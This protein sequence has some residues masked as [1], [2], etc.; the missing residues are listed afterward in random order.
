MIFKKIKRKILEI[1]NDITKKKKETKLNEENNKTDENINQKEKNIKDKE[2]KE[3][4]E[5]EKIKIIE[6]INN[7]SKEEEISLKERHEKI[8]LLLY[9][10]VGLS[11][12]APVVMCESSRCPFFNKGGQEPACYLP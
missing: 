4:K 2:N 12:V 6:E 11:R 8:Y 9:S 7:K 10:V 3:Y 1:K 5:L